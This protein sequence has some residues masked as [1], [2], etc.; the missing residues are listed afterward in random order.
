MPRRGR[1]G[2]DEGEGDLVVRP[3]AKDVRSTDAYSGDHDPRA[4]ADGLD[5]RLF[6]LLAVPASIHHVDGEYVHINP[7]GERASGYTDRR[8]RGRNFREILFSEDVD[9]VDA[10]FTRVAET[11]VPADFET[12]FRDSSGRTVATR[13]QYLP[14]IAAG[15]VVGLVVL[16]YDVRAAS[17]PPDDCPSELHLTPRQLEVLSLVAGALTTEEIAQRLSLS[18]ETVRN[19]IRALLAELHAHSRLQAV[20][21]AERLGLLPPRP[22]GRRTPTD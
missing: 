15:A 20:V 17:V 13:V 9:A 10:E 19:H 3:G 12:V 18:T 21:A 2:P 14:L 7:A 4:W 11:G 16:A 6:D 5:F 22:L 1:R 8:V